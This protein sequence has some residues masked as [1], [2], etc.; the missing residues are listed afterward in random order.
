MALLPRKTLQ[1]KRVIS[2]SDVIKENKIAD[3]ISNVNLVAT[4][5]PVH[6]T[7]EK[8]VHYIEGAR[9]IVDQCRGINS[10][11]EQKFDEVY[12]AGVARWG[13]YKG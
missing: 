5:P 1:A 13:E 12:K 2:K 10:F 11:L 7:A 4:D 6:W 3:Q 8:C 9:R